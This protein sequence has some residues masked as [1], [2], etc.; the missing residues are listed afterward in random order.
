MAKGRELAVVS[1]S[2]HFLS[3]GCAPTKKEIGG[4]QAVNNDS[5]TR[6]CESVQYCVLLRCFQQNVV[7][8]LQDLPF[9]GS[10]SLYGS[11]PGVRELVNGPQ[12]QDILVAN[13]VGFPR[14]CSNSPSPTLQFRSGTMTF[15]S[16]SSQGIKYST[17]SVIRL[18]NFSTRIPHSRPSRSLRYEN[19]ILDPRIEF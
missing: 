17:L 1:L 8:L 9:Y 6:R 19:R 7:P 3:C 12:S 13:F 15:P 11:Q 16:F 18:S 4:T 10:P 2:P 14:N 5:C